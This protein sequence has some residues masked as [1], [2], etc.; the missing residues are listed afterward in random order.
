MALKTKVLDDVDEAAA[1]IRAGGLVAFPTETVFGLGVDATNAVAVAKLFVAKGRP[2]D[3]PL[4]VHL[5]SMH[6]WQ[7]AARECPPLATRL[8]NAFSP[9]PLTIVLPKASHI[10]QAVTAELDTVGIRVPNFSVARMLISAA[11][12]PIAA[13]SANRSGRPSCT[14]WE[15]VLEDLDGRIDAVVRGTTS[16]IGIESTVVDCTTDPPLLLRPGAISLE[17]LCSVVPSVTWHTQVDSNSI[18]PQLKS[19]G[20][21]HAHYQPKATVVLFQ[22]VSQVVDF[23]KDLERVGCCTLDTVEQ[24]QCFGHY[25]KF[26]DV[27]EYARRFYEFLRQCDRAGCTRIYCQLAPNHGLGMA[28][29]DRLERAA[30]PT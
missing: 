10:V 8:M 29:N 19:P 23:P 12:L 25:A 21:R 27:A 9:G 1:I 24:H 30:K 3:N 7:L 22:F 20:L 14:T 5:D 6:H 18:N 11:S 15:S 16:E 13:P 4:I 17:E 2:S 26:L 28:L